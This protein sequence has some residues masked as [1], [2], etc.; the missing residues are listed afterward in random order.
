MKKVQFYGVDYSEGDERAYIYDHGVEVLP[1]TTTGAKNQ[2][3]ITLSAVSG[4]KAN[5][6]V[7]NS[8][9]LRA[10][11]GRDASGSV[12][13]ACGSAFKAITSADMPISAYLD[14]SSVNGS[15]DV[16]VDMTSAG[17]FDV[18]EMWLE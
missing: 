16:G 17:V 7:T 8:K 14:I 10:S 9:L 11:V 1:I 15:A 3:A 18:A 4:A 12:R 5:T 6:D 2:D 13:L